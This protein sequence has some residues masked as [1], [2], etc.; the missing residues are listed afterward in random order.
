MAIAGRFKSDSNDDDSDKDSLQVLEKARP[1]IWIQPV[2][3]DPLTW[4]DPAVESGGVASLNLA[5]LNPAVSPSYQDR[6]DR[7]QP[8]PSLEAFQNKLKQKCL[9]MVEQEGDENHLFR[10]AVSMQVYGM[11]GRHAELRIS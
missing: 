1:G 11:P 9:E 5:S 7:K 6:L 10:A 2:E 8:P 3:N 4:S